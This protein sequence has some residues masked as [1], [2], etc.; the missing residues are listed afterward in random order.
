MKPLS[1]ALLCAAACLCVPSYAACPL[2]GSWNGKLNLGPASLSIVFHI[3]GGEEGQPA[4]V[5]LDSPDQGATGIPTDVEYCQGDSIAIQV[6]RLMLSY[7]GRLKD[8]TIKGTF[9]QMGHSLPLEL[10]RGGVKLNRPQTPKPPFPYSTREVTFPSAEQYITLAGTLTL[11][12]NADKST[13]VVVMVSGSGQQ[14]RDEE[15]FGHKPFAVLADALAREGIC[16]LRYDDRGVG[17]STG[18]PSAATTRDFAL[19]AEGAIAYLRSA[20]YRHV[21]IFGHSEGGSIAFITATSD[22]KPDF[23][24][25]YGAPA[26][27]GYDII[28]DQ[29]S[30]QMADMGMDT[31]DTAQVETY[32]K[33]VIEGD[34]TGTF[35]SPWMRHFLAYDPAAD[36][37]AASTTPTLALYGS[38]DV[39]VRPT[40]NEQPMRDLTPQATVTVYQGLNHLMQ[41]AATGRPDEYAKINVTIADRVLQDIA[42]FIHS[43]H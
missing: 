1:T 42:A 21:G 16:S 31:S 29:L 39:Q 27:L 13:P 22:H 36:I 38:K 10:K 12:E 19:D 6:P 9:S 15:L 32:A 5:T 43:L 3:A 34:T 30:V 37:H 40:L 41:P 35:S 11:P 4:T 2:A 28:L 26:I 25:T 20:G 24:I 17:G 23:I 14:N 33:A 7:H 8:D 18:D